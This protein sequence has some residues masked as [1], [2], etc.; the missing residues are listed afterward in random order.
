MQLVYSAAPADLAICKNVLFLKH[1]S[2][3][4][5]TLQQVEC[6]VIDVP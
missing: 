1:D 6:K 3:R 4:V 2:W 5:N